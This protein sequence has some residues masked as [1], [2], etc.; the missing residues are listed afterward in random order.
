MPE[1]DRIA[2]FAD[3]DSKETVTA[4]ME[5]YIKRFGRSSFDRVF[6]P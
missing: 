1:Q 5:A 3:I 2:F 6:A 4:A